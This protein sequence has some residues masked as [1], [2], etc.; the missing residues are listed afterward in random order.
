MKEWDWEANAKLGL[1]PSKI[2]SGDEWDYEKNNGV[3]PLSLPKGSHTKVWWKC[4]KCGH[5]W[6]AEVRQRVKGLGKCPKCAKKQLDFDF[7]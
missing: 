6:K 7:E 1:D 3:N 5:E 4:S 2:S